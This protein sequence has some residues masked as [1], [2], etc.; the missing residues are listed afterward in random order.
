MEYSLDGG[1]TWKQYAEPVVFTANGTVSFRGTDEA[2]NVSEVAS[3]EV[4]NIDKAA[5]IIELVG[6]TTTPLQSSTLTASV[7]A[8]RAS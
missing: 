3:Y 7:G 8:S 5:P 6:D 1:L 4:T 2:G